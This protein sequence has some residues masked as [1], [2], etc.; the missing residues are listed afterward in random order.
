MDSVE[1]ENAEV[2]GN[3]MAGI[4]TAFA[5]NGSVIQNCSVRNSSLKTYL[6]VKDTQKIRAGGL[7]GY[8]G[9]AKLRN[10]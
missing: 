7:A 6:N 2:Y 1:I 8:A 5:G 3:Y 9:T 10:C 4:L